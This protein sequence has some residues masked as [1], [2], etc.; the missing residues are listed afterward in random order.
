MIVGYHRISKDYLR[1]HQYNI[2]FKDRRMIYMS[3]IYGNGQVIVGPGNSPYVG[4]NGNWW[5]G[6]VDLGVHAGSDI[7]YVTTEEFKTSTEEGV[8]YVSDN[9]LDIEQYY[10]NSRGAKYPIMEKNVMVPVQGSNGNWWIGETDLGIPVS[11]DGST[12]AGAAINDDSINGTT[13]YSSFKIEALL[14]ELSK[15]I[16]DTSGKSI[17]FAWEG[18]RLG[19]RIEGEKDYVFTD[20]L[21]RQGMPGLDGSSVF[22]A[23]INNDGELILDMQDIENDLVPT[24]MVSIE[25]GVLTAK[26]V[27]D[28]QNAISRL[29]KEIS[30]I[31]HAQYRKYA[32][33]PD[34]TDE[35]V[36]VLSLAGSGALQVIISKFTGTV[37]ISIDGNEYSTVVSNIAGQP[38]YSLIS[39]KPD[40]SGLY[41]DSMFSDRFTRSL[42][43]G[44]ST[45]I[46][47]EIKVDDNEEHAFPKVLIQGT[48][49]SFVSIPGESGDIGDYIPSE[50][51]TTE[52]VD[53]MMGMGGIM[54]YGLF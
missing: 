34:A 6:L 23:T 7:H 28:M 38:D 52:D 4:S 16:S 1:K 26:E 39:L 53:K 3:L 20:L 37:K 9:D 31:K 22:N 46:S 47:I 43:F 35:F 15:T 42:E 19:T 49:Y 8:Y 18:T 29:N 25:D 5:V 50:A 27:M 44:F 2:E 33:I 40:S 14:K 41:I 30:N 10:I 48:H 13:T 51:M 36:Q 32:V 54:S 45:G 17:E 24:H 11:G 21:G 12:I